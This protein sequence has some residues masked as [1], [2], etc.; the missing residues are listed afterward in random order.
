MKKMLLG[1]QFKL[2]D[3]EYKAAEG[4][5]E[6]SENLIKILSRCLRMFDAQGSIWKILNFIESRV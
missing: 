6:R 4:E 2:I 5:K 1:K 3:K